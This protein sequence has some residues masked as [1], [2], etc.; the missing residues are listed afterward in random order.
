MLSFQ[1]LGYT[2]V[3]GSFFSSSTTTSS[4]LRRLNL[5]CCS[6]LR[7]D[8]ASTLLSAFPN[9]ERLDVSATSVTCRFLS[10]GGEPRFLSK[11]WMDFCPRAR[12]DQLN[13]AE[14]ASRAPR[15]RTV[16]AYGNSAG[17]FVPEWAARLRKI[18]NNSIK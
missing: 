1:D 9:L 10:G 12:E 7:D 15:L 14:L 2:A 11:I 13:A 8:Y 18:S 4:Q 3:T 6:R 16:S 17:G 5:S